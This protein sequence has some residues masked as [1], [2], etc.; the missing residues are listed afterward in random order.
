MARG[1]D[2][3]APVGVAR[4]HDAFDPVVFDPVR[5]GQPPPGGGGQ[6]A[7]MKV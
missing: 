6:L 3:V 7:A 2:L 5:C 4:N 1:W